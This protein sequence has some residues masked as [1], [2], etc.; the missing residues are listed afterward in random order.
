MIFKL[1]NVK[2][3]TEINKIN[4]TFHDVD[5]SVLFYYQKM[6]CLQCAVVKACEFGCNLNVFTYFVFSNM[7]TKQ[8]T[9]HMR[10]LMTL[11]SN[12]IYHKDKHMTCYKATQIPTTVTYV[13]CWHEERGVR[14]VSFGNVKG[15][16]SEITVP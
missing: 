7:N 8:L 15:L 11:S 6:L 3:Q 10:V 2:T 1:M 14:T 9:G 5:V 4:K 12:T 16:S 13:C